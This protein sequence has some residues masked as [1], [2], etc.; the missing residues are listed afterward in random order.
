MSLP[1]TL[2][3]E[4]KDYI[5]F[6][7]N[8]IFFSCQLCLMT[9]SPY[10]PEKHVSLSLYETIGKMKKFSRL[11][12]NFKTTFCVGRQVELCGRARVVPRRLC[13]TS[14]LLRETFLNSEA[15]IWLVQ[16][17]IISFN[18]TWHLKPLWYLKQCTGVLH[19]GEG[20]RRFFDFALISGPWQSLNS[21]CYLS[22]SPFASA[23]L[24]LTN[25]CQ[26]SAQRLL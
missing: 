9:C 1:D 21:S 5:R 6:D 23:K 8:T 13:A 3:V 22:S 12:V 7:L 20:D 10:R 26:I 14:P 4:I 17:W 11:Q 24:F 16:P 18:C 2:R 15:L 25:V 19:Y